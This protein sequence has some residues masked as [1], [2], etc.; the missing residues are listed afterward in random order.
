MEILIDLNNISEFFCNSH[1]LQI[2]NN[3]NVSSKEALGYQTT[4]QSYVQM[5]LWHQALVLKL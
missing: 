4:N 3:G 5:G 2:F 1:E